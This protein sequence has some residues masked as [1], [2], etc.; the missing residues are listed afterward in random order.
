MAVKPPTLPTFATSTN[1]P[2]GVQPEAG[3]PTK[4]VISGPRLA[5]GYRPDEVPTAQDLNWLLN[6]IGTWTEYLDAPDG[7][8]DV[9]GEVR[10]TSVTSGGD[11]EADG[12]LVAGGDVKHGDQV[13][14]LSGNAWLPDVSGSSSR[15]ATPMRTATTAACTLF[16]P[17]PL[18]TGDRIK[19]I[20]FAKKGN[21]TATG[22]IT[23]GDVVKTSAAGA[24]TT[25]VGAGFIPI[26]NIANAWSDTTIDIT[27][28]TLAAGETVT[29]TLTLN[30]SGMSLGNVRVIFDRP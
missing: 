6:L 2:A 18:K 10:G 8:F 19:S 13:L 26:N 17:I 4:T 1:Y 7:L 3:T 9:N 25:I 30:E 29:M 14:V 27:D 24:D 16:L 23:A 11:I 28:T 22:D 15:N 21:G 5:T 12:N 20:I